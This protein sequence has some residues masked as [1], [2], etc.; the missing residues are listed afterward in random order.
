[1]YGLRFPVAERILAFLSRVGEVGSKRETAGRHPSCGR[2]TW[3]SADPD[4]ESDDGPTDPDSCLPACAPP[5][6]QS[7]RQ[8]SIT[9]RIEFSHYQGSRPDNLLECLVRRHP[10]ARLL[11]VGKISTVITGASKVCSSG[12][13][14]HFTLEL[15]D[16]HSPSAVCTPQK[17]GSANQKRRDL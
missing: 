12:S 11:V 2:P 14:S 9:T 7:E 3:C 5:S 10:P 6:H 15:P 16:F 4:I 13:K 17:P 1:M 8:I